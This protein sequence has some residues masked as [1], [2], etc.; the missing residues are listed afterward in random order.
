MIPHLESLKMNFTTKTLGHEFLKSGRIL[1]LTEENKEKAFSLAAELLKYPNH[2][3]P[4]AVY[5]KYGYD[6]YR[7]YLHYAAIY[8]VPTQEK[9]DFLNKLIDDN[10]GT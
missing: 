7:I 5:E 8:S 6:V 3:A 10:N 2:I 1:K 9:I 4:A